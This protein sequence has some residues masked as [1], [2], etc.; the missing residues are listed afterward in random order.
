MG[1][2]VIGCC[3]GFGVLGV[4]VGERDGCDVVGSF[5]GESDGITDGFSV[6]DFDGVS[7]G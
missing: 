3:A 4:S 5:V 7:D 2:T 1:C 6:G